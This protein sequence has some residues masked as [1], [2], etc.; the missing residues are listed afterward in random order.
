MNKIKKILF[1][2]VVLV[3]LLLLTG[4]SLFM[5][6][7]FYKVSVFVGENKTHEYVIEEGKGFPL[8][9][10]PEL[11]KQIF[12]GWDIDGDGKVDELPKTV[13]KDIECVALFKKKG[14]IAIS[15]KNYDGTLI[16]ILYFDL[17]EIIVYDGPTPEKAPTE[18]YVYVFDGWD[19]ELGEAT[20]PDEFT[21]KFKTEDRLY[22]INVH[23][24]DGRVIN[25]YQLKYHAPMP[26]LP[27]Q[28]KTA[29]ETF[30]YKFKG[31]SSTPDGAVES[32]IGV[33]TTN[34]EYFPVFQ[35]TYIDYKVEY[36]NGTEL[37]AKQTSH[38]NDILS[39]P[40]VNSKYEGGKYYGFLGFTKNDE[41]TIT[42]DTL[43]T[44]NDKYYV[45]YQTNNLLVLHLD[46]STFIECHNKGDVIDFDLYEAP[47]GYKYVFYY[48]SALTDKAL[49]VT[50]NDNVVELYITSEPLLE[51]YT[52]VLDWNIDNKIKSRDDLLVLFDYLILTRTTSFD[53]TIS[54][55]FD[56]INEEI[57]YVTTNHTVKDNYSISTSYTPILK[58]LKFTITFGER[59]TTDS[60]PSNTELST[61]TKGDYPNTRG[62]SFNDFAIE[63]VTKTFNCKTSEELFYTLEHGYKP[64]ITTDKL[65]NLYEKMK[66]VLRLIIS[67]DMD[68]YEKARA[69]YEWLVTE[70]TYDSNVYALVT[71]TTEP[72]AKY[73]CFYLEGV[74]DKHLAVCDGIS[75]AYACLCNM[76]GITCVKISGAAKT[77]GVRHAWNKILIG[78]DWYI[79]DATSG[80]TIINGNEEILTHKFLLIDEDSYK[81][82]YVEEVDPY[83]DFKALGKYNCYED[84][85]LTDDDKQ[86]SLNV[87][88]EADLEKVLAYLFK[89]GEEGSTIDCF[90]SFDY[91]DSIADEVQ[92][93][94]NKLRPGKTVSYY[95]DRSVLI[96]ILQ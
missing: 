64:V 6:K 23:D 88:G 26:I 27:D 46:D 12:L 50:M 2:I 86:I 56:D 49:S 39:Y 33:V 38:Y 65:N 7:K 42:T 37:I 24:F 4:C 85:Y 20:G 52:K 48:D 55:S 87:K 95:D 32:T 43:V 83:K 96:L 61:L 15:F 22:T 93:A 40:K 54:Y 35:K 18:K 72:T 11:E 29:D 13:D 3:F 17:G 73:H 47:S 71:G 63:K 9:T 34:H 79:V 80:G 8:L 94:L 76:E 91:G 58:N 30:T 70:V 92:K 1:S 44:G 10:E 89:Y 25:T 69:I 21:A 16:T 53:A 51:L 57:K 60:T 68:D 75:K 5:P 14:D 84:L 81:P 78:N 28:T 66:D 77:T 74:F 45:K 19:K 67:D 31:Y 82:Y 41:S 59:N 62:D 90:L 36:Y